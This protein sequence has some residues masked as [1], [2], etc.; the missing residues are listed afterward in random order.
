MDSTQDK[1]YG[2][3]YGINKNTEKRWAEPGFTVSSKLGRETPAEN[4][5]YE[6]F[7]SRRTESTYIEDQI[8]LTG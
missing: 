6:S 2:K 1:S 8:H 5:N 7:D 4:Q 3:V